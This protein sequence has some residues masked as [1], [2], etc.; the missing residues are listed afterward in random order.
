MVLA[1]GVFDGLH[2]GHVSYLRAASKLCLC[3]ETLMVAVAPDAYVETAKLRVP[4]WT[5][6][7]RALTVEALGMVDRVVKHSDAGVADIILQYH[8]RLLV[9]GEDW[10]DKLADDVLKACFDSHTNIL[11]L[12]ERATPHTSQVQ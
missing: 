10:K 6:V 3:G 8:P 1:S 7:D 9:K 12:P 5:W 4:K 2:A 11:F